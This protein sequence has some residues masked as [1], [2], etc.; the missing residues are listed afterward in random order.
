M[1]K[2][3]ILAKGLSKAVSDNSPSI[4]TALGISGLLGTVVLAV[5]A[6][7]EAT[8]RLDRLIEDMETE[9][10]NGGPEPR[11]ITFAD[12]IR[13]NWQLYIPAAI[14]GGSTVACMIGANS[15]SSRRNAALI[16]AYTLAEKA[17]SEYKEQVVEHIGRAKE[18]KVRDSVAQNKLERTSDGK[19][20]IIY[21]T[22]NVLCFDTLTGR[23]FESTVEKIRKAEIEVNRQCINEMYASQNDFYR[24][25]GLDAVEI[26]E[27]LGWNNDNPLEV[28]ISAL[29][30]DDKPVISI[31]YRKQPKMKYDKIW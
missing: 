11:V 21:G 14:V 24:H 7:P 28:I 5:R 27:Q 3:S 23:R 20:F 17:A 19:E 6:T 2:V 15:I 8:H 4:L 9:Y 30:E 12:V 22:G 18:Q 16:G 10:Q 25:L 29:I 13:L 1:N 26:G 31:D